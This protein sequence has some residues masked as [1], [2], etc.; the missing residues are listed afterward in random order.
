MNPETPTPEQILAALKK[1][2]TKLGEAQEANEEIIEV[3][4]SINNLLVDIK[5]RMP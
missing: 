4:C 5:F 3:L 2:E 1:I